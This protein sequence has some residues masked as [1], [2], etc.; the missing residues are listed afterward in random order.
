MGSVVVLLGSRAQAQQLCCMGLVASRHVGSSQIRDW[1]HVACVGRGILHHWATRE[2]LCFS[3]L[4][5]AL[6][7]ETDFTWI[8]MLTWGGETWVRECD[9]IDWYQNHCQGHQYREGPGNDS[10][11]RWP[12]LHLLR[13]RRSTISTNT[14][15][16]PMNTADILRLFTS[17][18][19][20]RQGTFQTQ[21]DWGSAGK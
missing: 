9:D 2:A 15:W 20:P 4:R 8:H 13:G 10:S 1:T 16:M 14:T 19:S 21:E 5:L 17:G 6:S 18:I 12:S 7:F 3:S 11:I